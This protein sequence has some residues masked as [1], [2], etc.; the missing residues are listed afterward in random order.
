MTRHHTT[1]ARSTAAIAALSLVA[2]CGGVTST[3]TEAAVGTAGGSAGAAGVGGQ[4][5]SAGQGGAAGSAGQGGAAGAG[6]AAPCAHDETIVATLPSA[7]LAMVAD[8]TMVAFAE[9]TT[10]YAVDRTGCGFGAPRAV[11]PITSWTTLALGASTI[12]WSD[13]GGVWTT[14]KS[15]GP[16]LQLTASVLS[17]AQ[18]LSVGDGIVVFATNTPPPTPH[19]DVRTIPASGGAE[20]VVL[21]L[22]QPIT[23]IALDGASILVAS[24]GIGRIPLT[25][26]KLTNVLPADAVPHLLA[27]APYEGDV[28]SLASVPFGGTDTLGGA[29]TLWRGMTMIGPVGNP[30]GFAIGQG[31]AAVLPAFTQTPTP[32]RVFPLDGSAPRVISEAAGQ[33]MPTAAQGVSITGDGSVFFVRGGTGLGGKGF[34]VRAWL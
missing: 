8:D 19:G 31:V 20:S 1:C 5:G 26:G 22:D 24:G 21:S 11:A 4:P 3:P 9:G 15:G 14:A 2:A 10:L 13:A 16:V 25:G 28:F 7:V 32:L 18:G 30:A 33:F 6:G 29:G 17:S 23:G 27:F 12:V 34:V